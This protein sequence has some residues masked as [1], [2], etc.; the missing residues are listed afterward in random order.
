MLLLNPELKFLTEREEISKNLCG[1]GKN[2]TLEVCSEYGEMWKFFMVK[3]K[4]TPKNVTLMPD[5]ASNSFLLS[6]N[7]GKQMIKIPLHSYLQKKPATLT[8]GE[9]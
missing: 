5:R 9:L 6:M 8:S 7:N 1:Q 4:R 3:I 2:L